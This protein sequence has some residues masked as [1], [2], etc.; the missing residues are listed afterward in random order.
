[1]TTTRFA[2][3]AVGCIGGCV[4]IIGMALYYQHAEST[5]TTIG[6]LLLLAAMFFGAAGGFTK[7]GP[8]T[9]KALTVYAFLVVAVAGVATLG[10]V[11]EVL[12][13]AVEIVLA[14]ILAVLA[15]IGIPTEN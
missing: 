10:E 9:P 3:L 4:S 15:Y 6:I 13:G 5:I 11:F 12:F 8:W 2:G 7:Y 14:I 1:M